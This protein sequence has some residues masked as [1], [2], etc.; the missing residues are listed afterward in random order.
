MCRKPTGV[1][2]WRVVLLPGAALALWCAGVAAQPG[3][4]VRSR[5][6]L[7]FGTV[8]RGIPTYVGPLTRSAGQW[9][10]RG[11]SHTEVRVDLTLP[12]ALTNAIGAELPLSFGSS[13]GAF[14]QQP[15]GRD[16]QIF[17]PQLPLITRYD[18]RG[19]IYIFLGGTALPDPVQPSGAYAATI[20]LTVSYTGN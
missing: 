3:L 6:D 8:I 18:Q 17:D 5:G 7:T 9:E 4:S 10:V 2:W 14:G 11:S 19:K 15:Q 1:R 16:A 12:T 20:S 13:D